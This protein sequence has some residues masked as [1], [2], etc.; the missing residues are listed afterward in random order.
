MMADKRSRP[1]RTCALAPW[2]SDWNSYRRS[3]LDAGYLFECRQVAG[4]VP[5]AFLN[6]RENAASES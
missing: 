2:H 4:A 1:V 5:N 3:K 6:E